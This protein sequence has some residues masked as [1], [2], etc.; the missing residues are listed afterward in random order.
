MEQDKEKQ[1]SHKT[2]YT[3]LEQVNS[4]FIMAIAMQEQEETFTMPANRDSEES[5]NEEEVGA[6]WSKWL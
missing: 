2:P 4:D 5:S 3:E 1:S 6:S